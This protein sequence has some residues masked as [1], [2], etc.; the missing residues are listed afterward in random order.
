[1]AGATHVPFYDLPGRLGEVPPGEVW[2]YCHSGYRSMV[3]ASLLARHGRAAVS[4]DDDFGNA[5]ASGVPLR[6]G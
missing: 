5:A 6:P 3:A 1:V 2:V 4:V